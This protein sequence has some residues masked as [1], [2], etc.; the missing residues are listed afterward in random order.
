MTYGVRGVAGS[1]GGDLRFSARRVGDRWRVRR[2][3]SSA[4]GRPPW[5]VDDYVRV[6]AGHFVVWMP[7][8]LPPEGLLAALADGYARI[9]RALPH[10]TLR[11]RYLVVVARDVDRARRITQSIRGLDGLT[12]LTDTQVALQGPAERVVGVSS[13]RLLVVWPAF[14]ELTAEQ[15]RQTVTH[16][17]T[18]AVLAPVTS[19]RLPAWVSEG[20]AEYVSGDRRTPQATRPTLRALSRP[21]S[22]GRL[23]GERQSEAYNRASAAAYLIAGRYGRDKLLALY[24]AFNRESLRGKAGPDLVDRALH[25]VLGTSLSALDR[26]LR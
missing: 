2:T 13:Q 6:S 14:T 10:R 17:L 7:R 22:I 12:A 9:R 20:V 18:H 5:L 3:P 25:R 8:G 16:E 19:G 21:G 24:V 26:D 4:R 11:R 1:F 15:Q 23:E